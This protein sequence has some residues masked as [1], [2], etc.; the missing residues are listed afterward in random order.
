MTHVC[1]ILRYYMK[2]SECEY[3]FDFP[4]IFL[5]F[6]NMIDRKRCCSSICGGLGLDDSYQV[7]LI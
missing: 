7:T 2:S 5:C 4:F 1:N 6:V 3:I